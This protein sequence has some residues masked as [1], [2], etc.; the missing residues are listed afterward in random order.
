[1]KRKK[2]KRSVAKK[3]GNRELRREIVKILRR[4]PNVGLQAKQ[5]SKKLSVKK[6]TEKIKPI[7]DELVQSNTI[8]E[9]AK[10]TY[11]YKDRE[12]L[13]DRQTVTGKV[14][15]TRRG[16][17]F[18]LVEELEDDIFVSEKKLNSA[19]N[20]DTVEVQYWSTRKGRRPEGE[21]IQVV[22]RANSQFIGKI[23]ISPSFAF[24]IPSNEKVNTDIFVDLKNLNG[25]ENGDIVILEVTDWKEGSYKNPEGKVLSVMGQTG[26]S[27][28]EMKTILINNGFNL[29]FPGQVLE[30]ANA[31]SDEITAQDLEERRDM[32]SVVTFTIDPHDAKDFD[33]AL[34]YRVLDNGNK[35]IGVHIADV[36]HYIKEGSALDKEAFERSTS[37]YLVD[38]VLPMLPERLS[39]G[40]CSLRP[41]E[42]KFT[43]SAVFEFNAE[44]K[45]VSRWFGRTLTHSDRR[46]T[47]EEAQEVI[48]SGEGDFAAE[49]L[50]MDRISKVLRKRKFKNGAIN[51]ET[52]E[53]RFKLDEEDKPIGVY[54]KVRKDA[55]MLIEDFMLLANREVAHF[56]SNK[57]QEKEIPFVY[58]VHDEPDPDKIV[59]LKSFARELGFE[60]NIDSPESIAYSFNSMRSKAEEDEALK[61]LTPIAIRTM[62]K[63]IYTTENI[64]HYGLAFT[65][66]THFTSP[67]RRY[68]DV[69]VHRLLHQNL[70]ERT[71][72]TDK[73]NLESRCKHISE[74]ERKAMDSERESVRYKQVEY[75]EQHIGEEFTGKISGII[76]RGLFVELDDNKC[77][78]M[79][80]FFRLPEPFE[81]PESRL[82]AIGVHTSKVFK[83]GQSVRIKVVDAD[84]EKRQ[85]SFELLDEYSF[86]DFDNLN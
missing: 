21:V 30:E 58:R 41:K 55:H 50:E 53:V 10:F 80:E 2:M 17:A 28:L 82:K 56:I 86:E 71:F 62:A 15:M 13:G 52:D 18:I 31:L 75:L 8:E 81:I 64:G 4:N 35:E 77:E 3:Y 34:S 38:R 57:G 85:V 72:R 54:L 84:K 59:Q 48:E 76:D 63:A 24:F 39:N 60:I 25:A 46:F 68:S 32:R 9:I 70:E 43:F 37:V 23:S 73:E 69:L 65:H 5:I 29:E 67:I 45:I 74:M 14:D 66:Y 22:K 40:L 44:D 42:D 36:A 20:G 33:D 47:Y 6:N 12:G 1:M 19:Q 49:I 78:G 51:F 26:D 61:M 27:D 11:R 7:L 83:M 79:I 16:A